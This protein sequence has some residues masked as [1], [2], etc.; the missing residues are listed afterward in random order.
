MT[1]KN[2]TERANLIEAGKRLAAVLQAQGAD[3]AFGVG[4]TSLPPTDANLSGSGAGSGSSSGSVAFMFQKMGVFRLATAG[5]DREALDRLVALIK[6]NGDWA[7]PVDQW[8]WVA[9][10]RITLSLTNGISA[11]MASAPPISG[12]A[13]NT[14]PVS[15]SLPITTPTTSATAGFTNE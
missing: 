6:A 13:R 4:A 3:F 11:V 5:V 12:N 14:Q 10:N 1:I 9:G 8:S 2:D 7:D 15:S